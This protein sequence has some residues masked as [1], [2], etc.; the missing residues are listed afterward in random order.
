M[1]G[2]KKS[3]SQKKP[4][5]QGFLLNFKKGKTIICLVALL[6][7]ATAKTSA[8]DNNPV[9]NPEAVVICGKAR[10]TVLTPEMIRIEY[11]AKGIFE[12]QATFTVT[13]RRLKVPRFRKREDNTYLY[14]VTDKVRLKYRKSTNPVTTPASPENLTITIDNN[15]CESVWYPGKSDSLN[16]KGTCR[17]LDGSNGDNKRA[18]MENGLI[19][20]SGWAVIDDSWAAIRSDGGRS[21][22]L[23]PN[24]DMEFDWW[25]E[26]SDTDALDIYYLGYGNDYK[27]AISDYTKIA[28]KIPL[29]PDYVFGYWYSKYSAYSADDYRRIMSEIKDNKIP[30]DVMILDM[31]WHWNVGNGQS[32]DKGGW[33]GWSWNT[34]LIPNPKGLLRNIHDNNFKIALNLHPADGINK[35]ESP[36]YFAAMNSELNGKYL[37]DKKDNISWSIDYTDFTKSFFK[38]IIRNHESE[39]VDFWWIDWQQHLTS[40]DTYGLSETFWCNHIFFNDMV[41]KRTDRRPVIFHRWGGLGSHR[42]QIGFSGDALINFPTLAF[43]PYFTATASNVGYGYWG[44]DLGGHAFTDEVTVNNPEL[45]LRWIQFGV[46]TPIFRTHATNDSRIERRIWKFSNFPIMLKAVRLRYSLFPYIYTMARKTYDTGISICRPLYYEYPNAEEA[47]LYEGEY[48]FGD[49]IL[50]API[51]EASENGK[52]TKTIWFPEGKW[53]SVATNELIEGPCRKT[54]CFTQEQIPYFFKQG[55]IIPYNP[56][57]VMN[58]TERPGHLI[59][60]FVSGCKGEG[61]LYEDDGDNNDYSTVFATTILRQ[62]FKNNKGEYVITPRQGI[63]TNGVNARSYTFRIYNTTQPVAVKVNGVETSNYSYDVKR[64]CTNIDIPCTDCTTEVKVRVVYSK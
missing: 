14:I 28:G 39:G 48:F 55:A 12:D 1:N 17:T 36:V 19:S 9:A 52:S 32:G 3:S 54:M 11:S 42:Y 62:S 53:W 25:A 49:D 41:R 6:M 31:D 27:K 20:R 26:R 23:R 34:N 56:P 46:F 4:L 40:N 30:A 15:G 22:A 64:K 47:Y 50:V 16:L 21:Y 45:L 57:T 59:L 58:V 61:V 2:F 10:F 44:H 37:N 60:N 51:T 13:N 8:S 7:L 33:T 29:P 63:Y 35:N 18:E 43:Q 5:Q 38:N 24:A